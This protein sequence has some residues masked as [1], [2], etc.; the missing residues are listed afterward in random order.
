MIGEVW[1]DTWGYRLSVN[2]KNV[3]TEQCSKSDLRLT[4]T[5]MANEEDSIPHLLVL[6]SYPGCHLKSVR[7]ELRVLFAL[8]SSNII[9]LVMDRDQKKRGSK[10]MQQNQRI[11]PCQNISPT[12]ST[13]QLNHR[14]YDLRFGYIMLAGANVASS[15]SLE[16]RWGAVGFCCSST[17]PDSFSIFKYVVL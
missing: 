5:N 3:N 9:T 14:Q 1:K 15:Y 17:P 7:L 12:S 8:Q 4:S 11:P 16:W 10:S 13:M 2:A 6:G